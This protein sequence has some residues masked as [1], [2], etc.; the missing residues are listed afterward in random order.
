MAAVALLAAVLLTY[1]GL[2]GSAFTAMAVTIG[3]AI[4]TLFLAL[5]P[6]VLPSS[7]AVGGL[8]IEN[9]SSSEYTLRVM[10]WVALI[11]TPLVLGYQGWTYW[12]FRKRVT[13][14]QIPAEAATLIAPLLPATDT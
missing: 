10:L 11:M 8:T 6:N 14:S 1:R 9:A 12:V 4:I 7:T 2:E 5:Y 13:R 3:A